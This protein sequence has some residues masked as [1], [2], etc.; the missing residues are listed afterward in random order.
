MANCTEPEMWGGNMWFL[1][2]KELRLMTFIMSLGKAS[3]MVY[4][5]CLQKGY[6]SY[7][8]HLLKHFYFIRATYHL[9]FKWWGDHWNSWTFWLRIH[10][11]YS[12]FLCTEPHGLFH[13]EWVTTGQPGKLIPGYMIGEK[14]VLNSK[15]ERPYF[16]LCWK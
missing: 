3:C 9:L 6:L 16:H 10:I 13:R 4:T 11:N 7:E 5:E 12:C 2:C 8:D 15:A 1:F 14:I